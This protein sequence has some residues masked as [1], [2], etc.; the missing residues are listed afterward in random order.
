[1]H[2]AKISRLITLF[3]HYLVL[4]KVD[5]LVVVHLKKTHVG[6]FQLWG[7]QATCFFCKF[8]MCSSN[9][10]LSL[11]GT[12]SGIYN[13]CTF[14][15]QIFNNHGISYLAKIV[16]SWLGLMRFLMFKI[17]WLEKAIK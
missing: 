2:N 4:G 10:Y 12:S 17:A 7:L 8:A 16:V 13:S 3:N 14:L 6:E 15:W 9:M 1:V 5:G 11:V